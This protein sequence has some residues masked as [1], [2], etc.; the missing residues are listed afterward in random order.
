MNVVHDKLL[1]RFVWLIGLA[2]LIAGFVTPLI[3]LSSFLFSIILILG[4]AA[5][6]SL[7]R[8]F[9]GLGGHIGFFLS[10][11]GTLLVFNVQRY[12]AYLAPNDIRSVVSFLIFAAVFVVGYVVFGISTIRTGFVPTEIGFFLL[13]TP[14]IVFLPPAIRRFAL[15]AFFLAIGYFVMLFVSRRGE[16]DKK[17][18]TQHSVQRTTGIRRDF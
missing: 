15:A 9:V 7:E 3:G 1:R 11:L 14:A 12:F 6:Y 17:I 4:T 5:V 16:Y 8:R 2:F 18:A 10:A 13:I